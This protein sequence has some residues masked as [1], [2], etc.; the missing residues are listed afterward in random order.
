MRINHKS[1]LLFLGLFLMSLVLRL[2]LAIVN[3]QANDD[4]MEVVNRIIVTGALPQKDDCWECFQPKLFHSTIALTLEGFGLANAPD[5]TK[6]LVAQLVNFIAGLISL[7]VIAIFIRD[8]PVSVERIKPLGFALIALNPQLV[9]ISSQ[10][11]NDGFAILFSTLALYLAYKLFLKPNTR[12]FLFVIL[13]SVLGIASKSNAWVTASAISL[14]LFTWVWIIKETRTKVLVY[15][16]SFL[17]VV[18]LLSVV[19]PLTQYITNTQKYGSPI[20]LNIP[21]PALPHWSEVT[22]P[23][24]PGIISIKDGYFTF[25]FFSLLRNPLD[26]DIGTN[27]P[28][29]RTSLW[30]Q[31]Y[32]SANSL[33]FEDFPPSWG[34]AGQEGFTV[35]R[36]IFILALL[37]TI[38][39]FFGAAIELFRVLKN[40][41]K[42]IPIIGRE[43][44]FGLFDFAFL[45][46]ILFEALYALVYRD[47]PV[48]KAIFLY[49]GLLAF[50]LIFIRGGD[51]I[52]KFFSRRGNW[53]IYSIEI[54][55]CGLLILYIMDIVPMIQQLYS[56]GLGS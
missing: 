21:K 41:V 24:R 14:A 19:N 3:R 47:Y 10:A 18:P 13:F 44:A 7:G 45:G 39:F 35:L 46:Y 28:S 50:A 8:L 49:P 33:R 12:T 32:A 31:L 29:H 26:R 6:I 4:H 27:I 25:K 40:F 5:D 30:T 38:I 23:R 53:A 17:L 42:R 54:G 52:Y 16:I 36:G 2:A 1:D 20:L 55:I 22:Y 48:M 34:T 51:R 9:R 11:T 43:T 15:A 37:P 56:F